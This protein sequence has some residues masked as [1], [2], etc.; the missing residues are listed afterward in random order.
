MSSMSAGAL[1]QAEA[2]ARSAARSL[3]HL[4]ALLPE[5]DGRADPEPVRELAEELAAVR[6][7]RENR[8]LGEYA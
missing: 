2:T 8:S 4:Q 6:R 1:G 3:E 5:E 7:E